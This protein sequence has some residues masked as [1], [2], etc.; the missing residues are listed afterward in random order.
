MF[1]QGEARRSLSCLSV[2][3]EIFMKREAFTKRV[4]TLSLQGENVSGVRDG[5][6]KMASGEQ[7]KEVRQRR[8]GVALL[9]RSDML[10]E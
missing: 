4:E 5:V 1:S 6:T 2:C 7:S 3:Q 10:T 9:L 8:T